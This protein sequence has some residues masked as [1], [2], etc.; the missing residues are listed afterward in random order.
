MRINHTVGGTAH[1]CFKWFQITAD[2]HPGMSWVSNDQK[3]CEKCKKTT[4]QGDHPAKIEKNQKKKKL[5]NSSKFLKKWQII[6]DF[7]PI[8]VDGRPGSK[9]F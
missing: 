7:T 6:F 1:I 5:R 9:Y 3:F 4:C 2:A 8:W